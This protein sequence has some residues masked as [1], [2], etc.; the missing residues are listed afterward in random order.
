MK[1]SQRP[2]SFIALIIL[3]LLALGLMFTAG[4]YLVPNKIFGS[5]VVSYYNYLPA[6]LQHH[7]LHFEKLHLLYGFQVTPEGYAV[8]K[9]TMGLAFLYL[10]F[11]LFAWLYIT[12]SGLPNQEYSTP[13]ALALALSAVFYCFLGMLFLRKMLLRYFSDLVAAIGLGTIF[14]GTNLVYFTAYEGAM[15]HSYVFFLVSLF[16]WLII[17]WHEK[18]KWSTTIWLGLVGGVLTL[19]RPSTATIVLF[20]AL[21]AVFDRNSLRIKFQLIRENG[22]KLLLILAL[23]LMIWLPQM[24]YWREV[25][26]HLLFFSYAGE[27]FFWDAP[28]IH[29][30]FF[31]YRNGWLMYS[32]VMIFSLIGLFMM[33]KE[34]KVL[35]WGTLVYFLLTIYII[36]SWWCWWWVGMGLRAM[37]ELYPLL[38]F[39][40]CAFIAWTLKRKR[41]LRV[42]ITFIFSFLLLF[43]LF[44][45]WQYKKGMIH[46]DGMTKQAYWSIFLNT[47]LPQGYYDMIKSPD[48][49]Q[50][51]KGNRADN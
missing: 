50:A 27:Q 17:Q 3:S 36:F 49:E 9:T 1:V 38:A 12:L 25:T 32:P 8:E 6:L 4:D 16:L 22:L 30:G 23:A 24:L 46:Y 29:Y 33:N 48:Y 39:P 40:L 18:P 5:D 19:V 26:G 37:I 20:A 7:S 45:N 10:P 2:I 31:S 41:I 13:Y 43:G 21:Y 34:L 11:Y 42:S 47:E 44:K 14:L 28:L 51:K 35:R 15:S